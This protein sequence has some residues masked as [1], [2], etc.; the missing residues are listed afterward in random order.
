[1]LS[2]AGMTL[3]QSAY[4]KRWKRRLLAFADVKVPIQQRK[5]KLHAFE[6]IQNPT[7]G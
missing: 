6:C 5:N 3:Q 2:M 1:M 7:Y 4:I